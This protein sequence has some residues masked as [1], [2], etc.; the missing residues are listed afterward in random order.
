[1]N[2]DLTQ[3]ERIGVLKKRK[4]KYNNAIKVV[5]LKTCQ[6]DKYQFAQ[7]VNKTEYYGKVTET[8]GSTEW[9]Q[10]DFQVLEVHDTITHCENIRIPV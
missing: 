9:L 6:G 10:T 3:E 8:L 1:M 5:T 2:N 4:K 7:N